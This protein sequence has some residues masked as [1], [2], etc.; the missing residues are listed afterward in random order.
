MYEVCT[1]STDYP[2]KKFIQTETVLI[3]PSE[4]CTQMP[5]APFRKCV[6]TPPI[7]FKKCIQSL[8]I[9][10]QKSVQ[11]KVTETTWGPVKCHVIVISGL[12]TGMRDIPGPGGCSIMGR[13]T[14]YTNGRSLEAVR[15]VWKEG[16]AKWW[17]NELVDTYFHASCAPR[18]NRTKQRL[19]PYTWRRLIRQLN[20]TTVW[21]SVMSV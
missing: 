3:T 19:F 9:A 11:G 7:Y 13:Y 8:L 10:L 14:Y 20:W 17:K 21:F 12:P 4:K 1:N 16:E 15:C 5:I 18:H 2:F 6:Y